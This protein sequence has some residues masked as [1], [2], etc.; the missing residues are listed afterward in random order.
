MIIDNGALK[1]I[2]SGFKTIF[3]QGFENTEA[4]YKK[5]AMIV[6]SSSRDEKYKW[7]GQMP[8]LREWIGGREI[9][10]LS[11]S[12]YTIENK[13][14]ELTIEVPRNDIKDDNI[15]IYTPMVRNIGE[16]AKIHP[17]TLV[18]SLL[19]KGFSEKCYD[20]KPFFSSEH[21]FDRNR[22]AQSNCGNKK[23]SSESYAAARS[24]MMSIKGDQERVLKIVPDLLVVPPQ[25]EPEAR[26][27]LFSDQIN[28]TTNIYKGTAELLVVPELADHPTKWYL[29]ATKKSIKPLVFQEREKP[30][31][32]SKTQ[33]TDDNVFFHNTY[34]YGAEARY[35]AGY[36]LWQLAYGSTGEEEKTVQDEEGKKTVDKVAESEGKE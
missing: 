1:D 10:H 27:I 2:Y 9:Q 13:D 29:L 8:T 33:D 23:L 3:N 30:H 5:V 12:S 7:L 25:L 19:S 21:Q 17:D 26:L 14:W 11:A 18:F 6:P 36:G 4:Q 24:C 20:G 31:F 32:V 16:E 22:A 15:G 35:N 28:G 34:F